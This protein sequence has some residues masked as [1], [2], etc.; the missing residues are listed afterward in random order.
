LI[1][2]RKPRIA[3]D[4]IA[5]LSETKTRDLSRSTAVSIL[6]KSLIWKREKIVGQNQLCSIV[7]KSSSKGGKVKCISPKF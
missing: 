4:R 1:N 3:A 5:R 6:K 7:T 2:V